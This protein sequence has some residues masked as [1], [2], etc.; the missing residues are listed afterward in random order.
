MDD[1]AKT[2][3][4]LGYLN[5]VKLPN[6]GENQAFIS[7]L[8]RTSC[9]SLQ[10]L[11]AQCNECATCTWLFCLPMQPSGEKAEHIF[12]DAGFIFL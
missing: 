5:S 9:S 8:A 4:N 11:C 12:T 2:F 3:I 7:C 6:M 1:F 10:W